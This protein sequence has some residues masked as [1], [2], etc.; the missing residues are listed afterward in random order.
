MQLDK[1]QMLIYVLHNLQGH[2]SVFQFEIF[3]LKMDNE[4]VS[5]YSV[6]DLDERFFQFR[7]LQI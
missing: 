6:F 4:S 2:S 7:T 1:A 5:L 3:Y